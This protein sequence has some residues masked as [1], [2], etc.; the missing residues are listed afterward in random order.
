MSIDAN[1]PWYEQLQEIE[2]ETVLFRVI[3]KS[4]PDDPN[5]S[6]CNF[7]ESLTQHI[8]NIRLK[9]HLI[10]SSFGDSRLYF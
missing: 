10:T 2:Q 6:D 9:S 1:M 5:D 7:D 4:H 3:A 8:A